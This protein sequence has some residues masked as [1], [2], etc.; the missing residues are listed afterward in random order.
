MWYE[1]QNQFVR[2]QTPQTFDRLVQQLED[3]DSVLFES[4]SLPK[5]GPKPNPDSSTPV[6]DA[7]NTKTTNLVS[8][9]SSSIDLNNSNSQNYLNEENLSDDFLD[10][11]DSLQNL[12]DKYN[13][14]SQ[15]LEEGDN[16]LNDDI[17]IGLEIT[18]NQETED[19]DELKEKLSKLEQ[20][21]KRKLEIIKMKDQQILSLQRE[22]AEA[23]ARSNGQSTSNQ[24]RNTES[25]DY[26]R[27]MYESV[28]L[29]FENLKK[30]LQKDG[31]IK[32]VA[33]RDVKPFNPLPKK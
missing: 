13:T 7:S 33:K 15:S 11:D 14:N 30:S 3:G 25:A 1:E 12:N 32:R 31:K 29:D 28:L 19:L 23:E 5:K 10:E 17:D 21:G 4:I 20:E 24:G 16:S 22:L 2:A 8:G 26:Y 18:D 6:N 9:E 27:G